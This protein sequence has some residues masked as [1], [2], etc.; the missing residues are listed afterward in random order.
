MGEWAKFTGVFS[1]KVRV[2]GLR[3]KIILLQSQV[4]LRY[5]KWC[6]WHVECVNN[7]SILRPYFIIL[8][9]ISTGNSNPHLYYCIFFIISDSIL[10]R[11]RRVKFGLNTKKKCKIRKKDTLNVYSWY[12][13]SPTVQSNRTVQPSSPTV[14]SNRPVQPSSLTVQSHRTVQPYSVVFIQKQFHKKF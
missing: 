5:V 3:C 14:Q 8:C 10:V 2:R 11:Y 9:P 4:C 12:F 7:T 13:S 1:N 6:L